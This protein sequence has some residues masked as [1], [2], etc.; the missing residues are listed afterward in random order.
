M[1]KIKEYDGKIK[2]VKLNI[3]DLPKLTSGLNIRSIPA[4]FLIYKGN[5]V[6]MLQGVPEQNLIDEFFKTG[7]LLN[8]MQTDESIMEDVMNKVEEMIKA[9]DFK[10]A[11]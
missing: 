11:H 4:V 8:Q 3:D 5:I 6:D 2:M 10:Q 7:V 9:E 1:E